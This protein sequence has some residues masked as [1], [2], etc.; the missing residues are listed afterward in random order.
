MPTMQTILDR[1][2]SGV[3]TIGPGAT[4]LEAAKLMNE[5][6]IGGLVVWDAD[7]AV[8]MFTERDILRRVV[9]QGRDPGTTTVRDV[10]TRNVVACLPTTTVAEVRALMTDRRIRHLPVIAAGQLLGIVTIGDLLVSDL[11]EQQATIQDL[12]S[13]VY[14]TR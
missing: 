8:G 4:V 3:V 12:T 11:Q 7:R 5:R 10:M 2:G 9:A 1:K 6:S 13:Y 14:G